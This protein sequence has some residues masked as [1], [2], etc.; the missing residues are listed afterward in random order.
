LAGKV[1]KQCCHP[2]FH[3]Y[4]VHFLWHGNAGLNQ[5]IFPELIIGF[6]DGKVPTNAIGLKS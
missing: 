4:L 3:S 5:G 1:K 6:S 2:I